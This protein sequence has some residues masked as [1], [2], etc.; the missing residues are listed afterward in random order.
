MIRLKTCAGQ[1]RGQ[2]AMNHHNLRS[3]ANIH[4]AT[5]PFTLATGQYSVKILADEWDG[6]TVTLQRLIPD[7]SN[8][9]HVQAGLVN[10]GCMEV[11]LPI[12]EFIRNGSKVLSLGGGKYRFKAESVDGVMI[13]VVPTSNDLAPS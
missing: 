10:S 13:E 1:G 6:G 8:C 5:E 3:F 4:G 2:I 12:R 9:G 11:D 7:A